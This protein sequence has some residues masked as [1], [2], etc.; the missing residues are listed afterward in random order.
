[1]ESSSPLWKHFPLFMETFSPSMETF[2]PAMEILSPYMETFSLSRETLACKLWEETT[3]IWMRLQEWL[4]SLIQKSK[5]TSKGGKPGKILHD[6]ILDFNLVQVRVSRAL[7]TKHDK[8]LY[9][10][11]E[12][13]I[14]GFRIKNEDLGENRRREKWRKLHKKRG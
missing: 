14:L 12:S 7:Q 3:P 8:I 1:M 10:T 2:S 6:G 4:Y 9:F 13:K 5:L 11:S